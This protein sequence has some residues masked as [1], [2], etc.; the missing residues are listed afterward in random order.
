M[1]NT[2]QVVSTIGSQEDARRLARQLVE[3]RLAACVQVSGPIESIY[4]WQ[5]Q[6]ETAS[7]WRLTIKSRADLYPQ[8]EAAIRQLH[9]YQTPE[10]VSLPLLA[11]SP[12]Y[13]AWLESELLPPGQ[14]C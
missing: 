4:W 2:I 8:L 6:L 12:A 11:G 5:G 10:I 9:S 14:P 1:T 7:E 3:R 13:L